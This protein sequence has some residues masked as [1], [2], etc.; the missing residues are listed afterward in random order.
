MVSELGP[1]EEEMP[2]GD[3]EVRVGASSGKMAVPDRDCEHL[4]DDVIKK[5]YT[6]NI[7]EVSSSVFS[8]H[9]L[10]TASYVLHYPTIMLAF[11]SISVSSTAIN[12]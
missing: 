3:I 9:T 12:T 8:S 5:L 2:L 1:P 6:D 4:S 7:G 11:L 10:L